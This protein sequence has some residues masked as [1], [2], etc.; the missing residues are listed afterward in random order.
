LQ[1]VGLD[2]MRYLGAD[3]SRPADDLERLAMVELH[4][5]IVAEMNRTR[6]HG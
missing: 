5:R 4:N 3:P 6:T 1:L 2:G